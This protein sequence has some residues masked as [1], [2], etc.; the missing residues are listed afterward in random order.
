MN[1]KGRGGIEGFENKIPQN[2]KY[3]PKNKGSLYIKLCN[4]RQSVCPSV[5]LSKIGIHC[6]IETKFWE[7]VQ[8]CLRKP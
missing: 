1:E 5:A 8:T 3:S 6:P 7:E 4:F 2:Q